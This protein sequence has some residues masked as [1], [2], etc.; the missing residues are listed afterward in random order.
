[1]W[2]L[3]GSSTFTGYMGVPSVLV[4]KDLLVLRVISALSLSALG[5]VHPVPMSVF[6]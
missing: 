5:P 2:S 1:M 4:L 3:S 6:V